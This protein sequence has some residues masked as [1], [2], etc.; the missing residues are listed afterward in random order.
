MQTA[1]TP[2]ESQILDLLVTGCVNREIGKE[3]GMTEGTV[4]NHL[5]MIF[6]KAGMN[7]RLEL[8]IWWHSRTHNCIPIERT[9]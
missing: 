6:D 2:R 1:M 4:K 9:Q 3:L 7:N 5:R 8:C